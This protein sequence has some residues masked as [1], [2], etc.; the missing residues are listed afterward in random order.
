VSTSAVNSSPRF[1]AVLEV[2]AA[3][4]EDAQKHFA[5]KFA[6]ET[7]VADLMADLNKGNQEIVVV[8]TRSAKSFAE[9]HIPGALNLSKINSETTARLAKDK[10]YVFY[11]WG[12]A[13]NSATKGAMR[14]AALGFRVKE[15]L[16]GIEYW[17]AEGGAVEG[18][19][20][21]NAPTYWSMGA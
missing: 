5:S 1:S 4:P 3:E 19:L 2:P 13:C 15:L 17:R 9:C 16:G 11:C 14:L 10:V 18:T 8:D 12:P 6:Y 7:D 20:G 21:K